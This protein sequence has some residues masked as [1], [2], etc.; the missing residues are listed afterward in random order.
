MRRFRFVALA[1]AAA[2]TTAAADTPRLTIDDL[3]SM[4]GLGD[5]VVSPDG[6]TLVYEHLVGRK[7]QPGSS[8]E[9]G[10][11]Q[12]RLRVVDLTTNA[13][14]TV[15]APADIYYGLPMLSRQAFSPSSEK[16]VLYTYT[17]E[18]IDLS[19]RDTKTGIVTRVPEPTGGLGA[20]AWLNGDRLVYGTG[21]PGFRLLSRW[22]VLAQAT[23][24]MQA[25][26]RD[27]FSNPEVFSTID[28]VADTHP[29]GALTV[30]APNGQAQ[31][32]VEGHFSSFSLSPDRRRLAAAR[33]KIGATKERS[34]DLS[35]E[36]G[37]LVIL[38]DRNGRLAVEAV[39]RDL[40]VARERLV[41][42]QRGDAVLFMG[43]SPSDKVG[44]LYVW[45]DGQA[46]RP[47][48]VGSLDIT[49]PST[50]EVGQTLL[51]FGW[52]DG[53]IIVTAR[54]AMTTASA[55]VGPAAEGSLDYGESERQR[56]DLYEVSSG[57]NRPLTALLPASVDAFAQSADGRLF[58]ISDGALWDI[59]SEPRRITTSA[60]GRVVAFAYPATVAGPRPQSPISPDGSRASVIAIAAD[61][62]R[63]MIVNLATG[64]AQAT[65][66]SELIAQSD[67]RSVIVTRDQGEIVA[68]TKVDVNGASRTLKT[69]NAD[70][71]KRAP[72]KLVPLDYQWQGE[73]LRS[74]LL[75]PADAQPNKPLPTIA[76]VYGGL[77]YGVAPPREARMDNIFEP[78]F[79]MQLWAAK[80]YAVLMPSLPIKQ[81][82]QMDQPTQL[83][84]AAIAAVD[85]AAKTGFVDPKRVGLLGQSYGGFSVAAILARR[86]DRFRT[87]IATAGIYNW[88]QAYGERSLDETL[89]GDGAAFDLRTKVAEQ[90][91]ASLKRPPWEDSAMYI[92]NSPLLSLDKIAVPLML[93]HADMDTAT[94]LDGAEQMYVSMKRAGKQVTLVRY[95]GEGH[96]YR[97]LGNIRDRAERMDAWFQRYLRD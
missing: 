8:W 2:M 52:R 97:G 94:A 30:L 44:R 88:F 36:P 4:E 5:A 93:V 39:L 75:L 69:V 95:F 91:Q 19:V 24:K 21:K 33:E 9:F 79:N 40:V 43:K 22:R 58:V 81:G 78:L 76:W 61:G 16:M 84:E 10:L 65:Y 92:R 38:R 18:R 12:R 85:Q 73:T 46:A 71:A 7:E 80:G 15:A 6:K 77:R 25:T 68:A 28:P 13:E 87:G 51:D 74:W 66:A 35:N 90:G 96:V 55:P 37:E 56:R 14:T 42:S 11:D 17:R 1:L 27:G 31:K 67:D 50:S 53:L 83:A 45:R 49:D 86:S 60:L 89:R 54:R 32:I 29:M 59:Q 34:L 3:F 70:L 48:D 62:A 57:K 47:V 72:G 64:Q 41:W 82:E 20:F 23:S 63:R 26:W